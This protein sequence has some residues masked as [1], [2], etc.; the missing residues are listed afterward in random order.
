MH[1]FLKKTI[2][3]AMEHDFDP[4]LDYTL[5]AC[6][7]RGGSIVSVGF[8]SYHT[9]Q[10]VEH[11][12]SLVRGS[13]RGYAL[14]THAEQAAVL[15]AREK[16]DL[17]GTKIYVARLRPTGSPDG[18]VGMARPC[19]ICEEVLRAYGIKRAYYTIDDRH[20]GFMRIG[21]NGCTDKIIRV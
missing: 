10:F 4:R 21:K 6:I 1:K 5:A 13:G 7:V 16:I 15:R 17:R 18:I 8:N 9:N 3:Y 20:Y 12:T 2:M 11:Y 14:S 19:E